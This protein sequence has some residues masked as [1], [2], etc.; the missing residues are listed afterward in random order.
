MP[1]SDRWSAILRRI[2]IF[3]VYLSEAAISALS[4]R[5]NWEGGARGFCYLLSQ[6]DGVWVGSPGLRSCASKGLLCG[7]WAGFRIAGSRL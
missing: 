1:S 2:V 6:S 4:L 7:A 5:M 3:P